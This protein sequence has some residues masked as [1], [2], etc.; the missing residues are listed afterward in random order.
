MGHQRVFIRCAK[1]GKKLIERLP[2]GIF[3]FTFG[4]KE[5]PPVDL[6]IAGSIKMKCIRKSCKHWNE[7][8]F[9]PNVF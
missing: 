5:N 2:N 7:I 8:T 9:L 6:L 1:C 4:G 3:K